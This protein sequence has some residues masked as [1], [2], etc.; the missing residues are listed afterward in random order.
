MEHNHRGLVQI[1]FPFFLWVM[2]VGSSCSSSR[3]YYHDNGDTTSSS[4]ASRSPLF[5]MALSIDFT[6]WAF[7][8]HLWVFQVPRQCVIFCKPSAVFTH[9][10]TVEAGCVGNF[11]ASSNTKNTIP[12]ASSRDLFIPDRWRSR[13]IE[14]KGSRFKPS[15][16]GHLC[17]I[18]RHE[19]S[20]IS[21]QI[22]WLESST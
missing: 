9:R 10:Y 14:L 20:W 2:A 7:F 6:T 13:W 16:R 21:H 3:V 15:Q 19:Y 5:Q 12:G 22:K 11:M 17:T 18:A 1:I 8:P 4:D